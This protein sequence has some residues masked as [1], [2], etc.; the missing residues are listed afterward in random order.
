MTKFNQVISDKDYKKAIA[1]H[2][3]G[4]TYTYISPILGIMLLLGL[5]ISTLGF[6][7][8]FPEKPIFLFLLSAFLILRPVFYIQ[9]IYKSIKSNKLSSNETNIR[10]TDDEKII[11]TSNGNLTSINLADLYSYY[12]SKFFL[13]LYVS[14]NQYLIIDKRQIRDN[15]D[16]L[17]KTLD[18][19]N[20]KKR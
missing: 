10:I 5:L 14:R 6:S 1:I 2:Y 7:N 12:D 9:N 16:G 8:V 4:Y 13:F 18:N 19:L 15:I 20:I 11:T 3:F 17:I